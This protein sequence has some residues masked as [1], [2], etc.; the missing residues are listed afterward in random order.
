M[1][2]IINSFKDGK[3]KAVLQLMTKEEQYLDLL[4]TDD[5]L[6]KSG[7]L[8]A[9]PLFHPFTVIHIKFSNLPAIYKDQ[10]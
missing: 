7:R 6:M 9:A 1:E 10:K 3:T 4:Q 8:K 5:R 2:F